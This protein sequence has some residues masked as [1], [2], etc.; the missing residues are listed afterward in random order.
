M[1]TLRVFIESEISS[2]FLSM[3]TWIIMP[4]GE[5]WTKHT[6][7]SS[8]LPGY[9]SYFFFFSLSFPLL[10]LPASS[11]ERF[12]LS[13][14]NS[15]SCSY[16]SPSPAS[17]WPLPCCTIFV[18]LHTASLYLCFRLSTCLLSISFHCRFSLSLPLFGLDSLCFT[19]DSQKQTPKD[20]E[21]LKALYT[22][23]RICI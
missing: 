15:S 14:C 1:R 9:L 3:R 23:Q 8:I 2:H 17:C 7:T 22:K 11:P 5:S 20:K 12:L 6:T 18:I 4:P 21:L 19:E 16:T 13:I 10:V